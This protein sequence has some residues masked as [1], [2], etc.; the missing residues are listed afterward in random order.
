M[1]TTHLQHH[2][3]L[4]YLRPKSLRR[5]PS[6]LA[7]SSEYSNLISFRE[8]EHSAATDVI[9][10]VSAAM[11]PLDI[12][13]DG[14][15]CFYGLQ[16]DTPLAHLFLWD[17]AHFL[18]VGQRITVIEDSMFESFLD[19]EYFKQGL[20]VVERSKTSITYQKVAK[21]PAEVDDDL[22]AWTFGIPV[23]PEDATVLN[24][25]V[26]RIL[27]LDIPTI[28][29]LLCGT[30]G[31]NFAYFDKVRIVGEDI[32][33]PPVQ[34]CKKKNRLAQE[35]SNNNLVIIHDR[36]F[37]PKNFG[38][39]VRSYGPR[40]PLMTMQSMFFD[41][42]LCWHP[43]RYSDFGIATGE[44]GKGIKGLHRTSGE[45]VSVAPST[46]TELEHSGFCFGS[47]LRY[48]S[49][50]SYPTG[51]MYICRTQVW[52]QYPLDES[53]FWVEYEDIEHGIRCSKAG[54]PT[55]LNPHGI[56]QTITSRALLGN[57]TMIETAGGKLLRSTPTYYSLLPKKPLLRLTA[58]QALMRLQSF[59]N[60]YVSD[61]TARPIPTGLQK[62][63]SRRWVKLMHETVQHSSF[64]CT[65]QGV[66]EFLSD[67]ERNVLFDQMP[68]SV[69]HSAETGFME[70]PAS[71]KQTFVT[72][73]TSIRG[74]IKQRLFVS[75]FA[76]TPAD[77]F[78]SRALSLPGII[79][80]AVRLCMSNGKFFYFSS[81][82][83]CIKSIYNSTPFKSYMDKSQ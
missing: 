76:D 31:S 68:D 74:M 77:Y 9:K 34:I 14:S 33:A 60:K 46:F 38:E 39:I 61:D 17:G 10:R 78:H 63:S 2:K 7:L 8:T 57:T 47:A 1:K 70:S 29:I 82:P 50:V 4:G 51:S 52:N 49:D 23:G 69:K 80:S 56:T 18:A 30:P 37:L 13:G 75:W 54:V 79:I 58:S 48:N 41:N 55:R 11:R 81:L 67:F 32:T 25:V 65:I 21:L 20:E 66:R 24:A 36:V 16:S 62:I 64:P 28:E 53:L 44:L 6:S 73:S 83:T 59:S 71:T 19:R 72:Q 12:Y 42:R 3:N 5:I 22:D 43:R 40:Y 45:A 27:E 35:A 26:K 15:F